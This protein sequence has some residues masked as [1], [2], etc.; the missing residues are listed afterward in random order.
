MLPVLVLAAFLLWQTVPTRIRGRLKPGT[1]VFLLVPVVV[2][3]AWLAFALGGLVETLLLGGNYRGW[4][5]VCP[6]SHV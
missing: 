1:E 4:L 2:L 6:R 5:L 3:G